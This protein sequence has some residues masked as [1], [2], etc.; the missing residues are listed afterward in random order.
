MWSITTKASGA[1]ND[2]VS[3]GNSA[4][5]QGHGG[6]K[7]PGHGGVKYTTSLGDP[8]VPAVAAAAIIE[9]AVATIASSH[10]VTGNR[11]IYNR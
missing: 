2:F 4:A 8:A 6:V 10:R 7:T 9:S 1:G 11:T 5:H 3:S